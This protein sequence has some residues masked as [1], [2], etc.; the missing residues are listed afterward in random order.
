MFREQSRGVFPFLAI[1][2]REQQRGLSRS[3]RWCW[4]CPPGCAQRG[5]ARAPGAAGRG[6]PGRAEGGL[7]GKGA[8]RPPR[9]AE[10]LARGRPRSAAPERCWEPPRIGELLVPAP[11]PTGTRLARKAGSRELHPAPAPAGAHAG[12]RGS[13][14]SPDVVTRQPAPGIRPCRHQ[15]SD[16][17]KAAPR[18]LRRPMAAFLRCSGGCLHPQTP[19]LLATWALQNAGG[20]PFRGREQGRLCFWSRNGRNHGHPDV[21]SD[22]DQCGYRAGLTGAV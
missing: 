7:G 21:H 4:L 13:S 14:N 6:G 15:S 18:G 10:R 9:P 22:T 8:P 16:P 17:E 19:H 1:N 20:T 2:C 12:E 3:P 5:G 11:C